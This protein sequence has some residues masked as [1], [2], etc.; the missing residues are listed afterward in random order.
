MISVIMPVYNSEKYLANA[1]ESVLLQT[2]DDFEL[3]LINDGSKDRSKEI[4]EKYAENDKRIRLIN[5]ENGGICSARNMGL[6]V[7]Q[8][9]YI[10]FIDNDDLY[11]NRLLE[12]NYNLAIQYDADLV[13]FGVKSYNTEEELSEHDLINSLPIQEVEIYEYAD[14]IKDYYSFREKNLRNIWNGLYKKSVIDKYCVKFNENYRFGFEDW[15]FNIDFFFSAKRIVVNSIPYYVHFARLNY[16]TSLSYDINRVESFIDGSRKELEQC[17][18]ENVDEIQ[19]AKVLSFYVTMILRELW[20]KDKKL[21]FVEKK[22]IIQSLQYERYLMCLKKN[23]CNFFLQ[24]KKNAILTYLYL[25]EH[26]LLQKYFVICWKILYRMK[27]SF[28]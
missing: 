18:K 26:F 28:F 20:G 23:F 21:S 15:M 16:S 25:H 14:V 7:A 8:G 24:S 13:R 19:I 4:C 9:D 17:T 1:I 22:K 5:K 3:I 6:K 10:A 27:K 2:Y 12:D 11:T